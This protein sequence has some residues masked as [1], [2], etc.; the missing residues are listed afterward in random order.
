MYTISGEYLYLLLS[1]ASYGQ[2][3]LLPTGGLEK[4]NVTNCYTSFPFMMPTIV[5]QISAPIAT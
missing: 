1:A 2:E 5:S 3:E 4:T